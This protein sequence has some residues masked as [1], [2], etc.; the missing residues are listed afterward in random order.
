MGDHSAIEWCDATYNPIRGMGPNRWMCRKISPG[1]DHCY[2]STLNRRFGGTEYS[3]TESVIVRLD[4]KALN[5]PLSWKRPRRVFVCSMTDLFGEWV[6]LDWIER[7]FRVMAS[8]PQHQFQVL[9]KRPKRMAELVP[10]VYDRIW[11]Y[12]EH[13]PLPNVWLGVSIELDRFAWRANYLRQA[14]AAV[15]FISAEPLLGPLP[16]LSLEGINWLIS[17]GESG[18]GHR[19]LEVDWVRDLRDR[20][21]ANDV[22][23]FHKQNGGR[24][25]A[26]GGR[27]LDGR[28]WD[29]FPE[30]AREP[31]SA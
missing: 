21:T 22:A 24:T 28:T 15:R 6:P 23:F 2:A 8:V 25:H 12:V 29:E 7:V 27:L 1:C 31:A 4:D 20:C 3:P 13:A 9:T 18:I 5:L 11:G 19:S 17:G 16:S 14:P 10:K 26:A 30:P